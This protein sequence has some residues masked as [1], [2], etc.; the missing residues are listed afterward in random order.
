[1]AS[2]MQFGSVTAYK[3]RSENCGWASTSDG[4]LVVVNASRMI[5]QAG[6]EPISDRKLPEVSEITLG[7]AAGTD[8][9]LDDQ[10]QYVG[11]ANNDLTKA[12]EWVRARS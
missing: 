11:S 7:V 6:A 4:M 9:L 12:L 8:S 1:M 5:V 10:A 2:K 3:I